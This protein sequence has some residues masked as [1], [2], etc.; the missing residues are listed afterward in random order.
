[1]L[2]GHIPLNEILV[3][4]QLGFVRPFGIDAVVSGAKDAAAVCVEPACSY[5]DVLRLH[6]QLSTMPCQRPSL[7]CPE[8]RR[9]NTPPTILGEDAYVPEHRQI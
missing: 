6:L 3:P 1:M 7:G 5:V 2:A 4:Q 8:E 9:A